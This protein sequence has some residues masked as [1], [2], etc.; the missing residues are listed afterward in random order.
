[1]AWGPNP[2]LDAMNSAAFTFFEHV[3]YSGYAEWLAQELSRIRAAMAIR[4]GRRAEANLPAP[5]PNPQERP[6]NIDALLE[7]IRFYADSTLYRAG[8]GNKP[9]QILADG[10]QRA[11]EALEEFEGDSSGE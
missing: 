1:M 10:G 11:R 8:R 2:Q 9:A 4:D 5:E 3:G 6:P 7:A